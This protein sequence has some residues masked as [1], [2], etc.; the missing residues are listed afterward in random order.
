MLGVAQQVCQADLAL[1]A[2][3][4]LR[5]VAV[6]HPDFGPGPGQ[7]VGDD[8]RG[9]GV[10]DDVVDCGGGVY[11]PLPMLAPADPRRRLVGGD[12][13]C[14][15]DFLADLLGRRQH[16]LQRALEDIGDCALADV[17]AEDRP[18]NLFEALKADRLRD[19]EVD[20]QRL[21]AGAKW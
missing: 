12:D 9:A 13:L 1:F 4:I 21:D 20:Q 8:L 2:M 5:A 19:V 7:E 18:H 17:E 3:T 16:W 15:A 14:P 6:R 10:G 11:D